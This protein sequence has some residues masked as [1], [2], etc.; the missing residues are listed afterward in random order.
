[1]WMLIESV[2]INQDAENLK[3]RIK[4]SAH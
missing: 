2:A 1:V 3:C 4:C